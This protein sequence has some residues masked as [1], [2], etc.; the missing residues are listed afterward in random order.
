MSSTLRRICICSKINVSSK[1]TLLIKL[2]FVSLQHHTPSPS[3]QLWLW[4][5]AWQLSSRLCNSLYQN[6]INFHWTL[7]STSL[8]FPRLISSKGTIKW[9]PCRPSDILRNPF[10]KSDSVTFQSRLVMF[11]PGS[12]LLPYTSMNKVLFPL[13]PWPVGSC[14]WISCWV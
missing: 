10:S 3:L 8:W 5:Q 11:L 4:V 7:L 9:T 14:F 13:Q 2:A 1:E 6:L 12:N